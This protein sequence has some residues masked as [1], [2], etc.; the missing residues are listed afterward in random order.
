[1]NFADDYTADVQLK[2]KTRWLKEGR[3]LVAVGCSAFSQST[4][5]LIS[6]EYSKTQVKV[7]SLLVKNNMNNPAKSSKM[8][9]HTLKE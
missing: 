4:T 1:M 2:I 3:E 7:L 5:I 6:N 9:T 8:Y